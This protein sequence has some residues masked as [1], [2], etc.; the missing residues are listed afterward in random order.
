MACLIFQRDAANVSTLKSAVPEVDVFDGIFHNDDEHERLRTHAA[1]IYLTGGWPSHI[2]KTT[3]AWLRTIILLDGSTTRVTEAA[4]RRL[5]LA[6]HPMVIQVRKR[7][8]QGYRI[9]GWGDRSACPETQG[10]RRRPAGRIYMIKGDHRLIVKD[11]GSELEG[12]AS[13]TQRRRR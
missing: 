6:T 4:I 10:L 3:I 8:A 9:A 1:H 2:R 13:P 11:D 5:A 7:Q 12:W